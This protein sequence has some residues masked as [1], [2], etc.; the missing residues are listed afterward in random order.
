MKFFELIQIIPAPTKAA[1]RSGDLAAYVV[2]DPTIMGYL[3]NNSIFTFGRADRA[4]TF[5]TFREILDAMWLFNDKFEHALARFEEIK[6]E[7]KG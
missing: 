2:S 6:A 1:L 3:R 7:R 4:R 5:A